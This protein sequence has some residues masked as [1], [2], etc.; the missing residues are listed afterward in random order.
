MCQYASEREFRRAHRTRRRRRR[1]A[2]R[3]LAF[4]IGAAIGLGWCLQ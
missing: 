3:R 1:F 4:V 2:W